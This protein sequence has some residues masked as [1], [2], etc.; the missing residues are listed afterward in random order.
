MTILVAEDDTDDRFLIQTAFDEKGYTDQLDFVENGI[1]LMSYLDNNAK[2]GIPR[3]ILLNLNMPK[4]TAARFCTNL[5]SINCSK[6]YP[7]LYLPLQKM[8]RKLP[9]VMMLAPIHTY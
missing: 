9:F 2:N 1:E 7:L 5:S 6:E 3:I 8:K 4:K